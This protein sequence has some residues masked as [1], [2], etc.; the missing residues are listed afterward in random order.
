ML[1]QNHTKSL[2]R[3]LNFRNRQLA[4]KTIGSI[5]YSSFLMFFKLSLTRSSQHLKRRQSLK[6]NLSTLKIRISEKKEENA[7]RKSSIQRTMEDRYRLQ[8]FQF[9]SWERMKLCF[10]KWSSLKMTTKVL[11]RETLMVYL[12]SWVMLVEWW[13][14]LWCLLPS[15]EP[16][17]QISSLA[18]LLQTSSISKK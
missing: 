14:Y 5:S 11:F 4:W 15:L 16:T 8:N 3:I 7:W 6:T 10:C 1:W 2:S 17:F 18:L 12:I 9:M 13:V